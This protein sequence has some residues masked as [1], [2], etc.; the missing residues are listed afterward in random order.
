MKNQLFYTAAVRWAVFN[1]NDILLNVLWQWLK[2][3]IEWIR[4]NLSFLSK[5]PKNILNELTIQ[6]LTIK[7]RPLLFSVLLFSGQN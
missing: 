3:N 5:A 6:S 7:N 2:D 1:N 4:K